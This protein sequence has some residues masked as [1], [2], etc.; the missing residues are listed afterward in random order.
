MREKISKIPQFKIKNFFSQGEKDIR[1]GLGWWHSGLSNPHL[2][3]IVHWNESNTISQTSTK[4]KNTFY[5]PNNVNTCEYFYKWDEHTVITA[6]QDRQS[7]LLTF[8]SNI[9]DVFSSHAFNKQ[10][11]HK[12]TEYYYAVP[13]WHTLHN[14][15]VWQLRLRPSDASTCPL[16]CHFLALP[17]DNLHQRLHLKNCKS[18]P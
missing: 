6:H 17:H 9:S 18:V 12:W 1:T 3:V 14:T 15:C 2:I 7:S 16:G 5:L 13:G 4:W 11:T 10:K 8:T